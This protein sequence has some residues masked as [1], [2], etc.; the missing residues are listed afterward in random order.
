MEGPPTS[1][2]PLPRAAATLVIARDG[3]QGMEVL[4]ARRSSSLRFMGGAMVFPGGALEAEDLDAAAEGM[5]LDPATTAS[6]MG[7]SDE[8]VALALYRC[9]LREAEEE[10]ALKGVP[11]SAL[12]YGGRWVTPL[13]A[14]IRFDT[15]FFI[16]RAPSGWEP[17]LD[18]SELEAA[19]WLTPAE[20]LTKLA[21]GKMTMAP[22]TVEML[23][24]LDSYRDV[25]SALDA[26]GTHDVIGAGEILSMRLSPL[27]HVVLAPN[28]GVMTGPGTNTY[29]VGTNR[30][31]VIDPAVDD[32]AYLD[33]VLSFAGPVAAVLV[34]HRHPDHVGGVRAVVERTGA[35]VR[36]FGGA[37]AGGVPV[38][39]L[40]D[41][42]VL[43]VPG[44]RLTTIHA[45]GHASD[46]V[47][48]FLEGTASLFA[49][50]NILGEGTAVI[51]PP[52]GDMAAYLA[53][54]ERLREMP[55]D[56]I[57]PGHFRP[58]DGGS[59]VIDG[60]IAHRRKREA[61]ILDALAE[62][63]TVEDVVERAYVDTPAHLHPVA[64][65]SA[66]AHLEM[67]RA[68]GRVSR[69]GD[70]WMRSGVY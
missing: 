65:Y 62:P 48:F 60:Y 40:T 52:D 47:C 6:R 63:L 55:I 56:R 38:D 3:A 49:G 19:Q 61:L 45:P 12:V 21:A 23:Q 69:R 27:V 70:K 33:A 29:I 36:A 5:G 9:A 20:A 51:A 30:T 16:T 15:R 7:E 42:E 18:P 17:T 10:V 57:Y 41:G 37:D 11:A 26:F 68:Q 58:L 46:H 8:R 31:F 24:H 32:A 39:P 25:A 50:D 54:L 66:L 35:P 22:P 4:L 67:L 43:E 34:T 1:G 13:G 53:S 64:R 59:A 28:P 2:D 44:A 14:P